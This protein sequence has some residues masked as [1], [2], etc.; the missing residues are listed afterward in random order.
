MA[1][2]SD[3]SGMDNERIAAMKL[4]RFLLRSHQAREGSETMGACYSCNNCGKCRELSQQLAGLCPM[5]RAPL[6]PDAAKC[7]ACGK[8]VPRKPGLT[9]ADV[10]QT[11]NGS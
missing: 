10:E 2:F 5:C 11:A 9:R 1:P 4:T 7:P 3:K 8:P 6:P